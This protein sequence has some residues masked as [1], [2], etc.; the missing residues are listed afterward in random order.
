VAGSFPYFHPRIESG[1]QFTFL[2]GAGDSY[3]TRDTLEEKIK[4]LIP[5]RLRYHPYKA[6]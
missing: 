1:I 5:K 4:S 3:L 2:R 6:K